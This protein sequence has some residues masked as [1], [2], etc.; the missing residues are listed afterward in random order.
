MRT[1]TGAIQLSFGFILTLLI[2]IAIVFVGTKGLSL[3]LSNF[4][5]I[6]K[7]QFVSDLE[8]AYKRALSLSYNSEIP[9]KITSNFDTICFYDEDAPGSLTVLAPY[10]E[11]IANEDKNVFALSRE[12][13]IPLTKLSLSLS[14][15]EK[16]FNLS[17]L[18]YFNFTFVSKGDAVDVK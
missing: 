11:V 2:I 6:Q 9:V 3:L 16:C 18:G 8:S 17:M 10:S 4:V 13:F 5:S 12:K 1:K 7:E 15:K 14:A